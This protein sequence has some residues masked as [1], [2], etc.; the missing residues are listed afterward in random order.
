MIGFYTEIEQLNIQELESFLEN[1]HSA[2]EIQLAKNRLRI[3]RAESEYQKELE[4]AYN[5]CSSSKSYIHYICKYSCFENSRKYVDLARKKVGEKFMIDL[6]S[7]GNTYPELLSDFELSFFNTCKTYGV[8]SVYVYFY[9]KGKF[10]AEAK[11]HPDKSRKVWINTLLFPILAALVLL[12]IM[13]ILMC[14]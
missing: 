13:V 9:P 4:T 12:S 3:L 1:S 2:E 7:A 10:S 6:R 14:I 11:K 5:K 8:Y